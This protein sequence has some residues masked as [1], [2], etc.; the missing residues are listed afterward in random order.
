MQIPRKFLNLDAGESI[1]F[2]RELEHILTRQHDV[3]YPEL[4]ARLFIPVNN[5][6]G[7]G[8]E[9]I[10]YYQFDKVGIAKI[11]SDYADDLPMADVFGSK[12]TSPVESLGISFGYSIQEVRSASHA[13]RALPV[14]K[15]NSAREAH[16]RLVDE[17]GA[18]GDASTGLT[19]FLN[20]AN[21]PVGSALNGG[22]AVASADQI[23]EDMNE[24]VTAMIT[25]TNNVESPDTLLLPLDAFTV[26]NQRRVPDTDSTILK[27]FLANNAW[28]RNVDHWYRL[29]GAGAGS[30]DRMVAYKRDPSKME[31][32]VPQEYE[33]FPVQ[34]RGLKFLVPTHSRIGGTVFYKPF[35]ALYR[36]GL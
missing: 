25:S 20:N 13:G 14:M 29:T 35:A 3:Q 36:D 30:T 2:A 16:E 4:R 17:L 15:A 23:I 5:E 21:V 8:A 1:F 27:F 31:L 18:L 32:H 10:T 34:E 11:I 24:A 22:W 7:P 33:T 19:G 9:S 12:F 28:I 26:V 6:A